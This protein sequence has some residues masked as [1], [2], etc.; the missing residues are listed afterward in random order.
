[1]A[2]NY[3]CEIFVVAYP[4]LEGIALESDDVRVE[5]PYAQYLW[6]K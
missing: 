2:L 6:R 5:K 1:V 4:L 3:V